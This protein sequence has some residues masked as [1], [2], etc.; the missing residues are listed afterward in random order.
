MYKKKNSFLSRSVLI[1]GD[2]MSSVLS[3]LYLRVRQLIFKTETSP[4][5]FVV[6]EENIYLFPLVPLLRIRFGTSGLFIV[7]F[8]YRNYLAVTSVPATNALI[9]ITQWSA[10]PFRRFCLL[11]LLIIFPLP[12]L[13]PNLAFRSLNN[14]DLPYLVTLTQVF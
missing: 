7:L 4:E 13:P 10:G 2:M 8:N 1:A 6:V 14:L 5:F 3:S 11:F 12:L 9:W